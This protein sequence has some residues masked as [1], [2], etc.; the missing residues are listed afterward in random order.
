LKVSVSAPPEKGKANKA[1]LALLAR[2][3][4]LP[5]SQVSLL[6][7]GKGRHKVIQIVGLTPDALEGRIRQLTKES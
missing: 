5:K 7:G 6:R 1:V 3:L 4:A 2:W